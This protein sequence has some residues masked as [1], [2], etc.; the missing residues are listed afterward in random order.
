MNGITRIAIVGPGRVANHLAPAFKGKGIEITGIYGRDADDTAKLARKVEA[1]VIQD[2]GKRINADLIL[3]CVSDDSIGEISAQLSSS[4]KAIVAHTSGAV[5]MSAI[6][7]SLRR[8]VFYPLQSFSADKNIV[9]DNVPF[10]IEA[11]H[12]EDVNLLGS[13]AEKLSNKIYILSSEQRKSLHLAAVF[14]N[15]FANL[16]F[17][18]SEE[19]LEKADIDRSILHPLILET[20][21]KV[22]MQRASESQTGPASR[23]DVETIRAHRELLGEDNTYRTIYDILT[24][25]IYDRNHH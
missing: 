17:E 11:E 10:C 15:N 9:W 12:N 22:L 4:N 18:F 3:L 13:V 2:I 20:A 5:P 16:M 1:P 19:L 24:Q 8:G 23:G 21:N 6:P 7:E 25:E 14:A